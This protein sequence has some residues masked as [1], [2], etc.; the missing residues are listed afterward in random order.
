MEVFIF[1]DNFIN[2]YNKK[3]FYLSF[4][5]LSMCF[6]QTHLLTL[7]LLF[8]FYVVSW[9]PYYIQLLQFICSRV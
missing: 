7:Q 2:V 8:L 1:F 4:I 5:S 6:L 3:L 9:I